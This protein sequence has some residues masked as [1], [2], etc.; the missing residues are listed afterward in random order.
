ML[1]IKEQSHTIDRGADFILKQLKELG[2]GASITTGIQPE[3]FN[4][5]QTARG[6]SKGET[7]L[8]EYAAMQEFG[9]K[10]S[11]ARPFMLKTMD[12]NMDKFVSQT[13]AGMRSIYNGSL[14]LDGLLKRQAKRQQAAMRKTIKTIP[15]SKPRFTIALKREHMYLHLLSLT[16]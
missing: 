16:L 10:K 14:T 9:T 5:T 6:K 13:M 2:N 11:R 12:M 15:Q 4:K 1:K 8:G 7:P 3:D